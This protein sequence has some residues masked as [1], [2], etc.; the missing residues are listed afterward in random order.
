MKSKPFYGF[1]DYIGKQ[2]RVEMN[3]FLWFVKELHNECQ[4][5]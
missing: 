5:M 3:I 1:G 4:V 2:V